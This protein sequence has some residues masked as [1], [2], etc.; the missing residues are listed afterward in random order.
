MP[1]HFLSLIPTIVLSALLFLWLPA[2]AQSANDAAIANSNSL[3]E[4]PSVAPVVQKAQDAVVNITTI[5]VVKGGMGGLRG[6]PRG[7]NRIPDDLFNEFFGLPVPPPSREHKERA[8]GSG[9][10]FDPEGYIITNNHVVDG[11]DDISVKLSDGKEITAQIIGRD[12]KTD[13]ALIKLTK[14]GP[15]PFISLG[16]SD[17]VNIGDWLVAIGNPFGLE[18]TVTAGILSARGRAIGVGPYDDFLQTDASINPGNS[19]GPLLNLKG[20]VVGINTIIIAGGTGIGFAIPSKV[21]IKIIDQLKTNGR[22]DRGWIGVLIQELTP[23][24]A[25]GFG[26]DENTQG[27]LVGSVVDGSPAQKGEIKHGD[28]I[29]QFD[30]KPI[31][32]IQEL[33][34]VVADTAIGKTVDVIVLRDKKPV[35]LKITVGRLEDEE[36]PSGT[37]AVGDVDLGLSLVEI[38]PEISARL[39]LQEITGLLVERVEPGSVASDIGISAE[40]I[41]LEVD[42][43]PV[44]TLQDY[45]KALRQHD[46]NLPL[47]LFVKRNNQTLY[48]SLS[49]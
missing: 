31:A 38:T 2:Q 27:A 43:K 18:H 26:I 33:T 3:V 24:M 39:G 29:T 16:D 25:K 12:P 17:K 45:Q 48:F 49:L 23:E 21:A 4:L 37:S 13:L 5:K 14:P 22:V 41:I 32:T 44:K 9:F 6:M 42:R 35:T 40:D 7:F 8:L 10:I 11:V 47:L 34:T 28:I 15:Y 46:K 1:K 19:G 36:L 30:G 20:E